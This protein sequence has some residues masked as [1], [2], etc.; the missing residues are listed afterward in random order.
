VLDYLRPPKS[1]KGIKPSL[2]GALLVAACAL[3]A[4]VLAQVPQVEEAAPSEFTIYG[5]LNA[6]YERISVT[7]RG[8]T[9]NVVDNASLLGF[10]GTRSLGER[11]SAFFQ[12]ENRIRLDTGETF[13]ASRA[14]Y[15]GIQ[16]PYGLG[17][18][19]RFAGP[20]FRRL[21]E[22]ISLHNNAAG[23]SADVFL[24][25][26]VTGNQGPPMNNGVWYTSPNFR[27]LRFDAA[28]A[29][30]SET[31]LPGMQQPRHL[32]LVAAYDTAPLHI[33]VAR[34]DTRRTSD[35]GDG[36]SSQDVAYTIGGL[37]RMPLV[38]VGGLFERAQSR[39]LTDEA[40][41]SYVRV[42]AMIPMDRHEVH[43]NVARVNHRL[44]AITSNDGAL[45]WTIAYAYNFDPKTRVYALYTVVNNDMNGNYGFST[46][47]PGVDNKSIALGVRYVF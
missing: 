21:Y 7:G 19:G 8:P 3:P 47:L 17:R 1:G 39:R 34:A 27:G 29:L 5:R 16:G 25:G 37:Y 40:R 46:R 26:T 14:S 41:R 9:W 30:L 42:I 23:S 13:W 44:D 2:R 20:V 36:T 33:A 38:V 28:Y 15:V 6:S 18:A 35:V 4:L 24:A 12:I 10:R 31:P 22:Y 43:F 11:L 45:Q 32:G